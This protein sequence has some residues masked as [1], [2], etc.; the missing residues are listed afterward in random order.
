MCCLLL[1]RRFSTDL[2]LLPY[3]L[4]K[5]LAFGF[6]A[7][8][9]RCADFSRCQLLRAMVYVHC[10]RG[11]LRTQTHTTRTQTHRIEAINLNN[12]QPKW[13]RAYFDFNAYHLHTVS[14]LHT[15][16]L[17]LMRAKNML[18]L[19]CSVK[20][21]LT[22][23]VYTHSVI[24]RW[25]WWISSEQLDRIHQFYCTKNSVLTNYQSPI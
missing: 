16:L 10:C 5:S 1:C 7:K 21:S 23:N 19:V 20:A 25:I 24:R 15:K 8:V 12:K 6:W 9:Q 2:W 18:S 3:Q 11:A 4:D 13:C 14:T 17:N 22:E